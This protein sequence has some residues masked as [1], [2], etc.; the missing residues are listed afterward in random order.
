MVHARAPWAYELLV[1]CKES[2]YGLIA[3]DFMLGGGSF[4]L[5]TGVS[6]GRVPGRRSKWW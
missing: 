5:E 1:E 2:K 3:G 4:R 6:E